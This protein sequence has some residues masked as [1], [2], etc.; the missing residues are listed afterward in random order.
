MRKSNTQTIG[1]V[2]KEYI[3]SLR[4]G[5]K[6]KELEIIHEWESLLGRSVSQRTRRIYIKDKTLYVELN[7]SV[8]RNECCATT[9]KT[10]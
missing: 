3:K 5:G 9:L 1:Q 7:S 10:G 4:I 6:L 8:V 2:L